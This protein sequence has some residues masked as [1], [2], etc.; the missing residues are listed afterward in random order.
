MMMMMSRVIYVELKYACMWYAGYLYI[1]YV[2]VG[3]WMWRRDPQQQQH[4]DN[5]DVDMSRF[6]F[7]FHVNSFRV[8]GSNF[9]FS[10]FSHTLTKHT[11][12]R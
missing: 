7:Q 5:C 10:L 6:F 11:S 4:K 8:F 2:C 3:V 12:T 9:F 1:Y